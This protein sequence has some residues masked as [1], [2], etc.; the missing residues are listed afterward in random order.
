MGIYLDTNSAFYDWCEAN[1]YDED[2]EY[3]RKEEVHE[4]GAYVTWYIRKESDDTYAQA[5][6]YQDYD[7]GREQIEIEKEGLKRTE[8]QVTTTTVAYE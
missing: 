1:G 7:N 8:K 6:A 3:D 2:T 5:F 4:R